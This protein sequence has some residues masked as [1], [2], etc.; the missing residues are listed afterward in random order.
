MRMA[1][2]LNDIRKA[3]IQGIMKPTI[4][5]ILSGLDNFASLLVLINGSLKKLEL[6]LT[7]NVATDDY[8]S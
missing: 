8:R 2:R 5:S 3:N 6:T 7:V 1:L 4:G